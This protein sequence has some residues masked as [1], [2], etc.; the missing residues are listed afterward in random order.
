M[1][2]NQ[3]ANSGPRPDT[4]RVVTLNLW[5]R[6]GAWAG[7]RS[8]LINGLRE[9]RPDLIAFVEA[10]KNDEYDQVSDLLGP[11][12]YAAHQTAREPHAGRLHRQPSSSDK[13][14]SVGHGQQGQQQQQRNLERTMHDGSSFQR[15]RAGAGCAG[16]GA[17]LQKLDHLF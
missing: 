9:L 2:T 17:W 4:I 8:M 1:T 6:S 11:G 15:Q 13:C 10:I 7:R 16:A 3:L 12:F 14:Q 5:G